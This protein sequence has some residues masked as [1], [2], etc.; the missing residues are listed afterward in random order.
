MKRDGVFVQVG[1]DANGTWLL[2]G[3]DED[4]AQTHGSYW[5]ALPRY[6]SLAEPIFSAAET[7]S[8]FEFLLALLGVRGMANLAHDPY[9]T[10]KRA[11]SGMVSLERSLPE[12]DDLG[13]H[14]QLWLYAHI[15]EASEPYILLMDL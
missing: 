14:L 13:K 1:R 3:D 9:E 11:I 15:M 7:K 12:D 8:E 10:T 2:E 4:R 6:L 5:E